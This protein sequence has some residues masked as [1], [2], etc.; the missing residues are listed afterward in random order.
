MKIRF[1]RRLGLLGMAA[2]AALLFAGSAS[3]GVNGREA[4]QRDRIEAGWENGSLTRGETFRLA[5]EQVRIERRERR[6]RADDGMLG[7][8]ERRALDRDL[9]RASRHI[10]RARHNDR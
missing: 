6:F 2:S 7:P 8:W 9:D 3:A 5:A 10:G 4:R 1:L